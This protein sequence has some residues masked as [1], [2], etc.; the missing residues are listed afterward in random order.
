[1]KK[2]NQSGFAVVEIVVAVVILALIGGVG[3]YV[4][5]SNQQTD[6]KLDNLSSNLQ[7]N[8]ATSPTKPDNS[9]ASTQPKQK[10]LVIKQWGVELPLSASISDAYYLNYNGSFG[11][12]TRSLTALDSSCAP[13]GDA[14]SSIDRQSVASHDANQAKVANNNWGGGFEPQVFSTRV[15]NYYYQF[16]HAQAACS[17]AS[18]STAKGQ[19]KFNAASNKQRA[20]MTAFT[21]A[22]TGLKAAPDN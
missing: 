3:Y 14:P 8:P 17:Q 12:G 18:T 7:K 5:H 19:A 16:S 11:L 20:D 2:I 21:T 9:V 13:N 4:Y 1:M 10:Y 22:F 15:G 6:K